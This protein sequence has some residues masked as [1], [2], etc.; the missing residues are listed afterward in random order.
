VNVFVSAR[1]SVPQFGQKVVF[2]GTE[3]PQFLQ[4]KRC[5]AMG[6]SLSLPAIESSRYFFSF[7]VTEQ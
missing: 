2:S 5:S 1:K 3:V 4:G 6:F 7:F